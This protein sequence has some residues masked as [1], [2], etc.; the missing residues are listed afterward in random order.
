MA[1]GGGDCLGKVLA[2]EDQGEAG[3]SGK[4]SGVDGLSPGGYHGA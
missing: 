4:I 3:P 1:L 2:H